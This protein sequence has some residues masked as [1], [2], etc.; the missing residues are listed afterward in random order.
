MFDSLKNFFGGK[1]QRIGSAAAGIAAGKCTEKSA[2]ALHA[3][4][5]A[6]CA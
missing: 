3:D 4:G 5:G 2:F 6:S 1:K